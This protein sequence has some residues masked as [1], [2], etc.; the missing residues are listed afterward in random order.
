MLN[1][2]VA[3]MIG[4]AA[5]VTEDVSAFQWIFQKFS[6]ILG[7]LLIPLD[8]YPPWLQ[9]IA[10]ALPFSSMIYGPSRLFVTPTAENFLNTLATQGI[11]IAFLGL[12]TLWV[13]RRGVAALTVNGG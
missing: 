5:F 13:Y 9:T 12:L 11:W 10:R 3:V 2:F 6:F 7:G 1:Y 4:L 8:F